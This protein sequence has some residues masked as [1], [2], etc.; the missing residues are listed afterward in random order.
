M[1]QTFIH[2]VTNAEIFCCHLL[3]NYSLCFLDFS[4]ILGLK[5][6]FDQDINWLQEEERSSST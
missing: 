5:F 2:A 1:T 3:G 6:Y 4:S